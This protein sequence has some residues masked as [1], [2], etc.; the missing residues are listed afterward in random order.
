MERSGAEREERDKRGPRSSGGPTSRLGRPVNEKNEGT[1]G[2]PLEWLG[3]HFWFLQCQPSVT[4]HEFSKFVQEAHGLLSL[5]WGEPL[6]KI[7]NLT[8]N[9]RV[10][11][12]HPLQ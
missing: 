5:G 10:V 9:I 8:S 3:K 4:D 12:T 6:S 1:S 11:V 7:Q 2:H